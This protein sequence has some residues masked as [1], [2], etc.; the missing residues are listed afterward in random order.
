MKKRKTKYEYTE[1]Q[2][3]CLAKVGNRW[4]KYDKDRVYFDVEDVL[5]WLGYR[6]SYYNTGNVSSASL[7]GEKISNYSFNRTYASIEKVWYDVS[8]G[9][10]MFYLDVVSRYTPSLSDTI[11]AIEKAAAVIEE[12]KPT[13]NQVDN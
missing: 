9:C 5:H 3:V 12:Q 7:N 13:L 6:W 10:Y 4:Q 2:L 8:E 11:D 1:E